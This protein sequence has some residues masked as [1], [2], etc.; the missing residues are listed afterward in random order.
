MGDKENLEQGELGQEE[1][2]QYAKHFDEDVAYRLLKKLRKN[3][4]DSYAWVSNLTGKIVEA[5]GHLLSVYKNPATPTKYKAGIIAAL[6]YIV[7]P[8][9]LI[10]DAVPIFGWTDDLG[11]AALVMVEAVMCYSD[12]SIEKLDEE[13]DQES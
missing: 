8:I 13:I 4:R 9:D 10:P 6:G 1:L 5:L 3:T 12:F 11:V 7:F 2:E